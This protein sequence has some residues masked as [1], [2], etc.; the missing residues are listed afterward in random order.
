MGLLQEACVSVSVCIDERAKQDSLQQGER[1][2]N[3][4]YKSILRLFVISF[5]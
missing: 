4:V 5:K 3:L 2:D 1:T